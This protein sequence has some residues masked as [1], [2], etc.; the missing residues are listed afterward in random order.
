MENKGLE[1]GKIYRAG[2][3]VIKK[4]TRTLTA[5][6]M[7][8]LRDN[9]NVPRE[10]Q[11]KLQRNGL[12]FI[13]AST[14]SGSWSIEWAFGMSFYEAIDEMPVNENG[15]FFGAGLDNLTMIL[16]CMFAD[17]SVVGNMEYM[18]KKQK[19]MH[20]YLK[21]AAKKGEM[22]EEEIRESEKAAD[23]VLRNEQH[24]ETLLK[25]GKEIEDGDD[26]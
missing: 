25:I 14:V 21:R 4:F 5:K 8:E 15:E 3:F 20:E 18:S 10:V 12:P 19:L 2:N 23:E 22:T 6:Q 16:T 11:K 24:K 7:Q 13:K 26:E 17:T 9:T 1:F